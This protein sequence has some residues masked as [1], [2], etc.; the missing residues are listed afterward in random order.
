MIYGCGVNYGNSDLPFTS[1]QTDNWPV[2]CCYD[3]RR[4]PE[5]CNACLHA[6]AQADGRREQIPIGQYS[7]S[8]MNFGSLELR[9]QPQIWPDKTPLKVRSHTFP[10]QTQ[11][12][13]NQIF[14]FS[15]FFFFG[16]QNLHPPPPLFALSIC[17]SKKSHRDLLCIFT[18]D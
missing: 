6:L 11:C 2:S 12:Q 18:S 16:E 14:F 8:Q 5:D 7:E 13:D 10:S 15:F 9:T 3:R 1:H 17:I 4:G